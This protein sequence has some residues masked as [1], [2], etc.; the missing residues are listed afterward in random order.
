[1]NIRA[2]LTVRFIFIIALILLIAF[3]L[4]YF[5]SANYRKDDF[6]TRLYNKGTNIA[7]LFIE[8][9]EVDAALLRRI[10]SD[11]PGSL[12]NER[13]TIY[14]YQDTVLFSTD[15]DCILKVDDALLDEVRLNGEVRFTREGYEV[16]AFLFT[17][18]YDRFVV[19]AG[20]KD[21]FGR[22][23]LQ[24]LRAILLFVFFITIVIASVSGWIFAGRALH[25][26]SKVINRV[27]E[28]S[29]SSLNLRV[30]E[31]NGSDEIAMMAKTFNSMLARLETSFTNQRNFIANA[32]HE[33]RTPLTSVTGQ[34]EVVL[35]NERSPEDYRKAIQSVLEDIRN[36]TV[37]ANRLLL[38]AQSTSEER[39]RKTR[40]FRI[41]EVIWQAKE[42][43][44]KRNP[45]FSLVFDLDEDL[46][47]E[48]LTLV[49]DEQLM[50]SAMSNLMENGCKYSPD[51]K[52]T[53]YLKHS[54]YNLRVIFIDKGIGIPSKDFS[55]V[56]EPFYRGS[57]TGPIKGH[58]IGLSMVK[59]IVSLHAGVIEITSREG[60]GTTVVVHFPTRA[61]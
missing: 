14:N 41:D 7:K 33:L 54:D 32:S 57:N 30:D 27:G 52:V 6:Y 56:F 3:P 40:E 51:H 17:S 58:G 20:A 23:K 8:V 43:L 60:E 59:A 11:N 42:E 38:L 44:Q 35:L 22:S 4:I 19:V 9:D 39:E 15:D 46:D 37:L 53:V 50:K 18:Q 21:I 48:K 5:S 31:G 34:L 10:E 28:I 45:E 12:P 1:M 25:P 55:K 36:L 61:I 26:I 49:G 13:I 16:T 2:K 47:D 24:N 29:I